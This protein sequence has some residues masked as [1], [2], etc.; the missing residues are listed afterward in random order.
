MN[1]E[2]VFESERIYYVKITDKLVHEYLNMI[3][4]EKV[5]KFI[6][7]KKKVYTLEKELDWIKRK[8]EENALIFSMIDKETNAYIGN[9][10]I[11]SIENNIGEL[12]ITITPNMQDKHYG[13]EA[14]K[15]LIEYAVIILKLDGL[16]LNVYD[17]NER[18]IHCDEKVGFIKDGIGKTAEDIHMVYKR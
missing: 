5:Q 12:G 17:T 16:E 7:H 8:L 4:D 9:I 2:V 11:M 18:G 14:I 10:E 3:N 13:Q 15:T 1:Y 6:S